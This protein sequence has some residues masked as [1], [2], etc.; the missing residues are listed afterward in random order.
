MDGRHVGDTLQCVHCSAH[1]ASQ[2]GSGIKRG[3][4]LNCKGPLCGSELCDVCIPL[5]K[6]LQGW[7]GGRP[8]AEVLHDLDNGGKTIILGP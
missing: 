6:R 5:E 1:W 3:W 4:C 8:K 2:P 7:E